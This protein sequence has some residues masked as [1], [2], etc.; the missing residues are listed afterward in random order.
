MD[1]VI[2]RKT[3]YLLFFNKTQ[4]LR[5][6]PFPINIQLIDFPQNVKDRME[7]TLH[8]VYQSRSVD[9]CS[10]HGVQIYCHSRYMYASNPFESC[11]ILES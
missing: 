11:Y 6:G 5:Y 2:L 8:T 3:G 4:R 10:V 7:F 9:T 1:L